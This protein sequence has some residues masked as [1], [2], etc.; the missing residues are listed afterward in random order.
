VETK[1]ASNISGGC[2]IDQIYVPPL[3]KDIQN[4]KSIFRQCVEFI[5][6][7]TLCKARNEFMHIEF[8]LDVVTVT[9]GAHIEHLKADK[10]VPVLN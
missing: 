10:V 7:D 4:S 5:D 9:R 8:G 2:I 6:K 1:S 3:P